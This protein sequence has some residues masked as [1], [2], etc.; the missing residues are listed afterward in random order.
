MSDDT[1]SERAPKSDADAESVIVE[2]ILARATAAQQPARARRNRVEPRSTVRRISA[3][4]PAGG[5]CILFL[6]GCAHG[7]EGVSPAPH[8]PWTPPPALVSA[9]TSAPA[10]LQPLA[11]ELLAARTNW[12]L[13]DVV[14]IALRNHS[15]TRVAWEAARAA[16]ARHASERGA[17][18]PRLDLSGGYTRQ[19]LGTA[20]DRPQTE[21]R[22]YGA[23]IGLDWLLFNFG[24][25]RAAIEETRQAL[26]A[27]DFIHHQAIQG[28]ILSVQQGYFRYTTAKALLGAAESGSQEAQTNLAAAQA[29]HTAGI[30]TL[31]DVLQARTAAA[32]AKLAEDTLLGQVETTRGVLATAMGLPANTGFDVQTPEGAPAVEETRLEVEAYLKRAER[33]RPDL[34]AAR[35]E[36]RRAEARVRSVKAEGYPE[37][38]VTGSVGRNYLDSPDRD[39]ETYSTAVRMNLPLFTGLSHHEDVRAAEAEAR[40]SRAQLDGVE[41]TLVLEVWTAYNN[42]TTA[43]RRLLASDE[44]LRSATESHDVAAGRYQSGVGGILDLLATQS[45]LENARATQVQARADWYLALAQL[46]HDTGT[47]G[48]H[49]NPFEPAGEE[50]TR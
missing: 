22:N 27:A 20:S 37:I 33:E 31:A 29:R 8:I 6:A 21:Q 3:H 17:Y 43:E 1:P 2:A 50:P 7:L 12:T 19:K 24:G 25:R 42:L 11:P 41:Q 28:V 45:A 15:V 13:A 36:A 4:T 35:A 26:Y 23:S 49:D 38:R 5:A 30:A 47:L 10:P 14:D 48:A 34:A 18:F 46:A 16:A 40:G 32:Q 39:Q 9:G 44:L